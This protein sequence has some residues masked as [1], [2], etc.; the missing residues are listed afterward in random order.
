MKFVCWLQSMM[1]MFMFLLIILSLRNIQCQMF[2]IEFNSIINR[3]RYYQNSKIDQFVDFDYTITRDRMF[4]YLT[5]VSNKQISICEEDFQSIINDALRDQIWALKVIDAWGKPLPSG[6]LK[7]NIYWTGN[8]DQCI[9]QL[10]LPDTK[11]FV[12]QPINTQYCM[13][14]ILFK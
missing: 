2:S 11:S 8:Y 7:G 3:I 9:Q 6:I 4:D 12:I 5:S 14:I 13:F 1:N 10:Y